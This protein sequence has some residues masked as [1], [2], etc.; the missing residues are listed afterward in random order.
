MAQISDDCF[1]FGGQMR[2]IDETAAL[3]ASKLSAV[4][5]V[6][7]V[8]LLLADGRVLAKEM[9]ASLALPP[10]TNSAVDGYAVRGADL[11]QTVETAFAVAGRVQ[12]GMAANEPVRPGQTVRIFTGAPMPDGADTVFMQEDVSIDGS[13]RILLPPGLKKG[14]NVRPAGEDVALGETVLPA[15]HRM[16]PQDIALAAALGFTELQ[17]RRRIRVAVFSTGDEI[18]AP[19]DM[20]G[21]A[22][23]FDS[24]R[25]MLTAMLARLCC[26]ITDLGI[27]VDD[28]SLIAEKLS[29]AALSHDLIL[30]SGG[31]STGE[32]D[33]VKAAVESAGT[34]VFWRVAIKPGRPVAMG[35]IDGTPLIGLPGNPVAS[36]VT[37]AHIARPAILALA[38]A[39]QQPPTPIAMRAAFSYSKKQG[40]REYV[41]ASVRAAADGC[42]EATKFP[43]EGAGLLS[44]LVATDGLVELGEE[45]VRVE[46]GHTVQFLPYS[47]LM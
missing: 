41:R 22:Q 27:L 13:G 29:E 26:D 6:E 9:V 30:T 5:E 20:R 7:T 3:I 14:A 1:A 36:F 23:L 32:A 19:G 18:V 17:V 2:P 31:V 45:I 44:S 25:F 15:G 46:P 12:A 47:S 24:N 8:P 28:S 21:Q 38:G 16:R 10:F 39:L 11:P 35:V 37:F 42:Y 40:R 43:R 4:E 33:C 34:L